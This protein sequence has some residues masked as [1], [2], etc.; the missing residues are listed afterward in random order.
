MV[1]SENMINWIWTNYIWAQC[2]D[3]RLLWFS[4]Y[5]IASLGEK[6]FRWQVH[7][8]HRV[9]FSLLVF[10]SKRICFMW[11]ILNPVTAVQ[12]E[13]FISNGHY[14]VAICLK[15]CQCNC[16]SSDSEFPFHFTAWSFVENKKSSFSWGLNAIWTHM[17]HYRVKVEFMHLEYFSEFVFLKLSLGVYV[18][19][20]I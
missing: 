8:N 15:I 12:S 17:A 4:K 11:N 5:V 14:K 13:L 9:N 16:D 20:T 3:G 19:E 10:S 1:E 7:C 2:A 18:G 6:E